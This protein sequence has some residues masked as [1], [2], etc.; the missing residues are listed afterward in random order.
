M[1]G[2]NEHVVVNVECMYGGDVG[3][4]TC[5]YG[6]RTCKYDASCACVCVCEGHVVHVRCERTVRYLIFFEGFLTQRPCQGQIKGR[7][8]AQES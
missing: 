6:A 1:Y 5:K 7:H 4:R 2:C 3:E 8:V